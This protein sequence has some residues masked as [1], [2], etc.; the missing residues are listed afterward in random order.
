MT[1]RN[2]DELS[3]KRLA[4]TA[5]VWSRTLSILLSTN[6]ENVSVPVCV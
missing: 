6:G 4:K 3:K 2:V 5:W 1:F